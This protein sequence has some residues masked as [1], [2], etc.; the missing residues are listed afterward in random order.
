MTSVV[1]ATLSWA[2]RSVPLVAEPTKVV[3]VGVSG[4]G[5][6]LRALVAAERRGEL[7]GRIGLVF[8]DRPCAAL[9]W[10]AA[11]GIPT[12]LVPGGDDRGAGRRPRGGRAGRDR[13]GRLHAH[14]RTGRAGSLCRTDPQHPSLAPAG[15]PGCP[16]HRRRPGGRRGR[17]RL[18]GPR[19][20]RRAGRRS[21]RPAGAGADPGHGRRRRAAG[22]D[23]GRGAPPP[24]SRRGAPAGGR[25]HVRGRPR[26]DRPRARRRPDPRAAAGPAVGLRQDRPGRAR[27]RAGR[28]ALR[29]GLDRWHGTD[30]SR[31]RPAGH[32]RGR[33]DRPRRDARRS[34]QDAPSRD[35]RRHPRRPPSG[36][37][38]AGAER[39]G[40]RAVRAGRRQPLSLRGGGRSTGHRRRRAHRGDR[41]RWAGHGPGSRQE[42]C[43]RRHRHRSGRLRGR[44]GGHRRPRRPARAASPAPGRGRLPAHGGV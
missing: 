37:T 6:N 11:E 22:A 29:A 5:S 18:H 9:D 3:A 16:R 8:A 12:A 14:R 24:A 31:G 33:R 10:A 20:G 27:A 30:A 23:P 36:R 35:P 21:D 32:R 2:P 15:V 1:A 26:S 43:Q 7:G 13:P 39:G 17:D 34:G 28:R 41:H 42:P 25:D 4:T 44:A 40:D 38:P 19:R